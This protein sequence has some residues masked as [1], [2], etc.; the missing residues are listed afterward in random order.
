MLTIINSKVSENN[1]SWP[2]GLNEFYGSTPSLD[3]K[4]KEGMPYVF[5]HTILK[6]LNLIYLIIHNNEYAFKYNAIYH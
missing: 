2:S 6:L 3:I 5:L 4:Y 1:V